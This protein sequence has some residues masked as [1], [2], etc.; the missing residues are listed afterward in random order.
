MKREMMRWKKKQDERRRK[1]LKQ[2]REHREEPGCM[3]S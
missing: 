3:H 2:D 1:V